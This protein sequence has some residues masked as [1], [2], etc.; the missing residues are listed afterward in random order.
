[1][2]M[3]RCHFISAQSNESRMKGLEPHLPRVPSEAAH[4][5]NHI[6]PHRA[7]QRRDRADDEGGQQPAG[8]AQHAAQVS[9]K[10]KEW[11]GHCE[12]ILINNAIAGGL[13]ADDADIGEQERD[14]GGDQGA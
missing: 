5:Q 10:E 11:N 3:G 2:L 1:M 4:G 12:E 7:H 13:R 9:A 8:G 14:Q 6:S